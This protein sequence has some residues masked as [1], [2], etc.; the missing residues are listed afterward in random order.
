MAAGTTGVGRFIPDK[1]VR[2][3]AFDYYDFR[4]LVVGRRIRSLVLQGNNNIGV[5]YGENHVNSIKKYCTAPPGNFRKNLEQIYWDL[6]GRETLPFK[7]IVKLTKDGLEEMEDP[8][9]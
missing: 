2:K 9:L 7:G 8:I 6:F 1:L 3:I 5:I 4:D